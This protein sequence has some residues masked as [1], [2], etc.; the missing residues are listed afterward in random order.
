MKKYFPASPDGAVWMVTLIL[1]GILVLLL[2]LAAGTAPL[3]PKAVVTLNS[4]SGALA[5]ILLV[6]WLAKPSRYEV[7]D[8]S[9]SIVRTWPFRNI[10]VPTS[11]IHEVHHLSLGPVI[12]TGPTLP[13]VFGYAG[14]FQNTQL[15]DFLFFGTGRGQAVVLTTDDRK[16]VI[17]PANPKRF[18]KHMNELMDRK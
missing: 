12:P 17:S 13:Y 14:E 4:I 15:G 8:T 3:P 5:V 11:E 9:I 1:A 10:S 16:Y 18:I 6:G 7:S 2:T